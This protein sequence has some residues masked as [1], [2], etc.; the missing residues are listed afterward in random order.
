MQ[1][2]VG[3][4]GN[5]PTLRSAH[6]KCIYTTMQ[7]FCSCTYELFSMI[8]SEILIIFN[9]FWSSPD[10]RQQTADRQKVMHMSK[11]Q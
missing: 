3:N 10:D 2:D 1:L 8:R 9:D 5:E 4:V 7:H 11:K 6:V